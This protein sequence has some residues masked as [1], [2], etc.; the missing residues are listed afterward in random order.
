MYIWHVSS[1]LMKED[2]LGKLELM[3][4]LSFLKVYA[5]WDVLAA[6][7]HVSRTTFTRKVLEVLFVLASTLDEVRAQLLFRGKMTPN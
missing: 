5:T 2:G 1:W 4:A 3:W 6:M 7:W